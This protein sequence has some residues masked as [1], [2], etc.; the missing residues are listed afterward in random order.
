MLADLAE[1]VIVQVVKFPLCA[2][3]Q[4]PCIRLRTFD[5]TNSYISS[6]LFDCVCACATHAQILFYFNYRC[7]R[8][9]VNSLPLTHRRL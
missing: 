4:D 6:K 2:I 3:G 5:G 1:F 8:F 7:S 9:N